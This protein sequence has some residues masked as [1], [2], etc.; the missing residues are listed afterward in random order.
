MHD[1]Y[2]V[3][4]LPRDA[5]AQDI[6]SAYRKLAKKYHPDANPGDKS[7]EQKFKEVSQAHSI[8][9]D[10]EKRK[11]FDNGEIDANGQE[12]PWRG[13]FRGQHPGQGQQGG[14]A[15]FDFGGGHFNP[16]DIFAELFGGRR[17]GHRGRAG[18]IPQRGADVTGK[19]TV[20][21]MDAV[22]GTTKRIRLGDDKTLDVKIAAGTSS[23]QVL[24]L[25]GQGRPGSGGGPAGDAQIEIEVKPHR[26]FSRKGKN[27]HLALPVTLQEAVL[28]AEVAVPT[29]HGPVTLRI[30]AGSNNGATLRLKGKGICD[31]KSGAC[32]D[33]YV[34]LTLVL[35]E[36]PDDELK[37]FVKSWGKAH[38]YDPRKDAGLYETQ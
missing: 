14:A 13:G 36:Q 17:G 29:I 34:K 37:S 28:G 38:S 24:R 15:G 27:I 30:P 12:T 8:L 25:K 5:S 26:H 3:L 11:R 4:N 16:E 20:G 31:P 9:G 1:P 35:P 33:Q 2:K 21:F 6:K 23:G 7:A 19:V 22:Q 10:P 18:P 32:G